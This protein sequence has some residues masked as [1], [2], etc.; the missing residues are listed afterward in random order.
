M[1]T[2]SKLL[3][4]LGDTMRQIEHGEKMIGAQPRI[5][6]ECHA[7][8]A[9]RLLDSFEMLQDMQLVEMDKRFSMP[10]TPRP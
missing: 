2:T 9:E 10:W 8:E 4:Q 7:A 5:V 1:E 3:Q 6:E